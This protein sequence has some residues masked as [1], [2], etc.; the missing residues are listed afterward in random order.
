MKGRGARTIDATELQE[1]T[2]D[3]DA[4]VRKDRFVLVDAVG[5]TDS[6][7]V[8]AKPLVPAGER[9]VSLAKLLDKAG[10]KSI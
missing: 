6:P 9:Q 5:V 4:S 10:T 1:V 8:D 2:P 3:A 7:L